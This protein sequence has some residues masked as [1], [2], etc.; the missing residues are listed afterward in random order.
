MA[1]R[2]PKTLA[3]YTSSIKSGG[4][5]DNRVATGDPNYAPAAWANQNIILATTTIAG[6]PYDEAWCKAVADSYS[7]AQSFSTFQQIADDKYMGQGCIVY[8]QKDF[9]DA[10]F[11][12]PGQW[13]AY[14]AAAQASGKTGNVFWQSNPVVFYSKSS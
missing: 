3:G 6:V 4:N 10:Q 12:D 2:T 7:S 8:S 5:L 13:R 11:N 1:A 14:S 9:T